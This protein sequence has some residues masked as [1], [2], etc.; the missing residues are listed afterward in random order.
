MYNNKII[1]IK[2]NYPKKRQQLSNNIKKIFDNHYLKNRKSFLSQLLE[3]WLHYSIKKIKKDKINTLEIGAGTLNHLK[4]ENLKN[5]TYDIIEP[6]K[7]LFKNNNDLKKI[8]KIYKTIH[9]CKN[10]FY[11]RIISCAVLEHLDDLPNFLVF[12]SLKMKKS[13][14][15]S[16]SIPCEGYP[17]W[18]FSWTLISG[19][20][21]R[22]KTGCSFRE[23]QKYEHLNN[24]DEILN[25]I[26]FFYKKVTIK[27]SYPFYNKYMSFY[28]NITF[29]NPNSKN[30]KN[31]LKYNN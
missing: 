10:N 5:N 1:I 15:Q 6:K 31:Y 24:F 23:V 7:F 29:S 14:F 30:I 17:M 27:Y 22:L 19:F 2:K 26:E 3:S 9:E 8:N 20:L 21:F 18:D 4:Y 16:H 11:D 13:S 28:A 12:S 25:L